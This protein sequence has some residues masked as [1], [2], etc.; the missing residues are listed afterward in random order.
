MFDNIWDNPEGCLDAATLKVGDVLQVKSIERLVVV[1]GKNH[2]LN[3]RED[4]DVLL[5]PELLPYQKMTVSSISL[6]TKHGNISSW[7]FPEEFF[8]VITFEETGKTEYWFIPLNNNYPIHNITFNE[9]FELVK[10]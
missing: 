8:D 10:E 4:I 9:I 2:V 3:V 5:G 7:L 1:Y 6:N